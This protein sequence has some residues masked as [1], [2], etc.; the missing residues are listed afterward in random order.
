MR[1]TIRG[2][3]TKGSFG[4]KITNNT[5]IFGIMGGL[6]PMRNIRA[7][8]HIGYRVG[9]ARMH[10]DIPLD[11]KR[12]LAYMM[13]GNPVDK[14]MLSRNPQC[15][16]GVGRMALVSSRGAYTT[17]AR[18]KVMN[19]K[20]RFLTSFTPPNTTINTKIKL[21]TYD[22]QVYSISDLTDIQDIKNLNPGFNL[23][24]NGF[25]LRSEASGSYNVLLQRQDYN[26]YMIV[27]DS[28]N[29]SQF[30]IYV[31]F[32]ISASCDQDVSITQDSL[33]DWIDGKEAAIFPT[34][35]PN[36]DACNCY[37]TWTYQSGATI[38]SP[39]EAYMANCKI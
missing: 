36:T 5:K 15:A 25:V 1:R 17:P 34:S 8:T 35:M 37:F 22:G 24:T 29:P 19:P 27:I 7:S 30:G 2:A 10:Q 21:H 14:Y 16:G 39:G 20:Y 3:R 18:G 31:G 38:L 23:A 6:A 33:Y 13:G 26:C 32:D 28:M 12:G 9:D 11:P 4:A